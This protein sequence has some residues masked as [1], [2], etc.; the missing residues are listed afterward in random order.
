MMSKFWPMPIVLMS[1]LLCGEGC[2]LRGRQATTGDGRSPWNTFGSPKANYKEPEEVEEETQPKK[3]TDTVTLKLKY[4]QWM[5]ETGNLPEAKANYAEVLKGNAKNVD[6][7]LGKARIDFSSGEVNLAEQGFRRALKVDS[8]SAQAY[9]GLGQ[10]QA[11]KKEWAAAAESLAKASTGLPE[12]KTI[13][14]QLA[15]ALVHTGN[16]QAAQLQFTQSVGAA[17]G[18]YNTALILKDEGRVR[19]AEEQLV[20][21][22]RKDPSLKEAERWLSELRNS[23][24]QLGAASVAGPSAIQPEVTQASY[25]NFGAVGSSTIEPAV[26]VPESV[27]SPAQAAGGHSAVHDVAQK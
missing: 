20:L 18:H 5:E 4:A 12:D 16:L 22:L 3:I 17:A 23:N 26:Y 14:H 27:A 10:C 1:I 21:A 13:R 24:G 2:S 9:S 11:E 6:A 25:R 7:I 19:E 15:I 8:S